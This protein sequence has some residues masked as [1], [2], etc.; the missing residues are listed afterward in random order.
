MKKMKNIKTPSY[1]I[2]LG[3]GSFSG[4]SESDWYCKYCGSKPGSFV[5]SGSS[6][7]P[8]DKRKCDMSPTGWCQWVC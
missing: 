3:K 8:T 5:I 7:R 1:A 4:A 6:A 2:K